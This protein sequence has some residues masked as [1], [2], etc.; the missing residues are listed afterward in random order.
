MCKASGNI[1]LFLHCCT[2]TRLKMHCSCR[3][4]SAREDKKEAQS[5]Q[6]LHKW[7]CGP[8]TTG[9]KGSW[10]K[11]RKTS[12]I[13]HV[14]D[15]VFTWTPLLKDSNFNTSTDYSSRSKRAWEKMKSPTRAYE[16]TYS[17]GNMSA[18]STLSSWYVAQKTTEIFHTLED[19]LVSSLLILPS[20]QPLLN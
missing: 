18:L 20:R 3:V 7:C 15:V 12:A 13:L 2:F 4:T 11:R 19:S 1:Y 10:R 8:K 14:L 5:T 16:N 9:M 6:Y 17:H